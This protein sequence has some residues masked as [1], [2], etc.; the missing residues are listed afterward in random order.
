[1]SAVALVQKLM[2]LESLLLQLL[3]SKLKLVASLGGLVV[4]FGAHP[5]HQAIGTLHLS[6]PYVLLILQWPAA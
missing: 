2:R 1:M 4:L 3:N 6:I 5:S